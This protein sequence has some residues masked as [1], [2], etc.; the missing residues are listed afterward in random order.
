MLV[1]LG[2]DRLARFLKRNCAI[3]LLSFED[4]PLRLFQ[5]AD[6]TKV[7]YRT[8]ENIVK[9]LVEAEI[10]SRLDDGYQ[11]AQAVNSLEGY[12]IFNLRDRRLDRIL[13]SHVSRMVALELHTNGPLLSSRDLGQYLGLSKSAVNE[14]IRLLSRVGL[15]NTNLQIPAGKLVANESVDEIPQQMY[16]KAAKYFQE[17]FVKFAPADFVKAVLLYGPVATGTAKPTDPMKVLAIIEDPISPKSNPSLLKMAATALVDAAGCVTRDVGMTFSLSMCPLH[18]FWNHLWGFVQT[19][20]SDFVEISNG[21]TLWGTRPKR[22]PQ[23]FLEHFAQLP[24]SEGKRNEWLA[25]KYLT[26]GSDGTLAL[27]E[28]G[29]RAF[30][31]IKLTTWASVLNVQGKPV[32]IISTGPDPKTQ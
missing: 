22:D 8:C 17:S 10:V 16:A 18:A 31:K 4:G 6:K 25:K 13:V 24:L 15:T 3:V 1:K 23:G 26:K 2:R 21:I 7:T 30:R 12:F 5:I 14:A 11:I 29:V 19:P 32:R 20:S 27:T 28:H 9:S